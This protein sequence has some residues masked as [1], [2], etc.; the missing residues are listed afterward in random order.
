MPDRDPTDREVWIMDV[1]P[2][3]MLVFCCEK[4]EH[5]VKI[6]MQGPEGTAAGKR[7]LVELAELNAELAAH[8]T[9]PGVRLISTGDLL[10]GVSDSTMGIVMDALYET[11]NLDPVHG[12]KLAYTKIGLALLK[13]IVK[14]RLAGGNQPAKRSRE[15]L[16]TDESRYQGRGCGAD[17]DTYERDLSTP[18]TSSSRDGKDTARIAIFSDRVDPDRRRGSPPSRY[19]GGRRDSW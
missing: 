15:E 5:C 16:N 10:T 7:L 2:R 4:V 6:W 19:G 13:H 12:E 18:S 14:K 11:L 8:L 3:F 1:L 9:G 17:C